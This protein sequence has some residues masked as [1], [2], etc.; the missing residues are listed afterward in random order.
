MNCL[1][2]RVGCLEDKPDS[3]SDLSP[4]WGQRLATLGVF[5][6]WRQVVILGIH[7][8][9][10]LSPISASFALRIEGSERHVFSLR[11]TTFS[12]E[13][14]WLFGIEAS[15]WLTILGSL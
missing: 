12:G 9:A 6:P 3:P 5:L 4:A 13:M 1:N 15:L 7:F 11:G 14:V 2:L 8:R 10:A